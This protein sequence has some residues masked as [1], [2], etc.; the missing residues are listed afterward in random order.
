MIIY[1]TQS[2]RNDISVEQKGSVRVLLTG[3][4]ASRQQSSVDIADLHRHMFD[5]SLLGMH[6]LRFIPSPSR[7]LVAGLG[8]GILPREISHYVPS[9]KIDVLEI[10][11]KILEVAREFFLFEETDRVK[12]HIGDAYDIIDDM[13]PGYDVVILDAYNS[14]YIPLHLMYIEFFEKIAK[15]LSK[16]SVV[17]SNICMSHLSSKSYINGMR[18]AISNKM[19]LSTGVINRIMGMVFALRGKTNKN[20]NKPSS[21]LPKEGIPTRMK[22]NESIKRSKIFSLNSV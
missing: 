17:A 1:R 16:N 2:Q 5:Y 7:V 6:S 19:Y 21:F 9:C 13:T 22:L 3:S 10:D 8:A 20:L 4:G 14:N 12:V 11:E 15:V 18:K